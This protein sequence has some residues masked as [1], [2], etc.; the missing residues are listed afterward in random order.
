MTTIVYKEEMITSTSRNSQRK[1]VIVKIM[2]DSPNSGATTRASGGSEKP[3]TT[4]HSRGGSPKPSKKFGVRGSKDGK[5][6]SYSSLGSHYN[7][8]VFSITAYLPHDGGKRLKVHR[9][10]E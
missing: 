8:H 9:I 6:Q 5:Q 10:A 3:P 1:T 7:P 2:G 4:R